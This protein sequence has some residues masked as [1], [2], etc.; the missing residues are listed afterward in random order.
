MIS[1]KGLHHY[2]DW[3]HQVSL[4][5]AALHLDKVVIEEVKPRNEAEMVVYN[6]MVCD[7]LYLLTQ[8]V[9]K[10]IMQK[11]SRMR[12][13][14]D[15]W[16]YRRTN[17]YRD[18][19][20]IFVWQ[21]RNLFMISDKFNGSG[22]TGGANSKPTTLESFIDEC[23]Q[24]YDCIRNLVAALRYE[25]YTKRFWTQTQRR[26]ITCSQLCPQNTLV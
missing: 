3:S 20:F 10:N 7:S 15:I 4:L 24:Q 5:L 11:I 19:G 14:Y 23:E 17:Y 25:Q 9:S 16:V 18:S 26:N 13:T 22:A 2:D 21:L 6:N 1:S 12:D 8:V